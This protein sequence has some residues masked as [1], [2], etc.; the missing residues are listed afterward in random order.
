LVASL[1]R[2]WILPFALIRRRHSRET[3]GR[4]RSPLR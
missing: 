1:W 4:A 3:I 2:R